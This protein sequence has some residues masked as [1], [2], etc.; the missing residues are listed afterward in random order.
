[1]RYNF[2]KV[3]TKCKSLEFSIPTFGLEKKKVRTSYLYELSHL[4]L[5]V[6]GPTQIYV[7]PF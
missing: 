3:F 2:L 4:L 6:R 1:M 5:F 7:K